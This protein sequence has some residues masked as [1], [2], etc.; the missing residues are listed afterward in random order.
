MT[1][2]ISAILS[3]G[4]SVVVGVLALIGVVITNNR[5]Q[6]DIAQKIAVAQ[7]VTDTKI[8]DLTRELQEHNCLV[9]RVPVVEEQIRFF[10]HRIEELEQQTKG[11]F[12]S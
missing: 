9:R 8:E 5:S 7:A 4:S 12:K 10:D 11:G 1:S 3:A 6:R 2:L